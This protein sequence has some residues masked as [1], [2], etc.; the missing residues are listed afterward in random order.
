MLAR[1][2]ERLFQQ[3]QQF[4]LEEPFG[5]VTLNRML[6]RVAVYAAQSSGG[7]EEHMLPK[8]EVT[9]GG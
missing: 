4:F 6:A 2:D 3:W 1:M 9:R 7:S 8:F 5:P